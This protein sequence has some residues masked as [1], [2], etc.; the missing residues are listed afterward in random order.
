MENKFGIIY[1]DNLHRELQSAIPSYM[2]GDLILKPF[3]CHCNPLREGS[4]TV[5]VAI[6][7]LQPLCDRI[8]LLGC[9]CPFLLKAPKQGL[10]SASVQIHAGADLFLPF[11]S[12]N[13]LYRQGAYVVSAGWLQN[14]EKGLLFHFSDMDSARQMITESVKEVVLLDSGLHK[15]IESRWKEFLDFLGIPGRIIEVGVE[16]L[17]TMIEN[18]HQAWR[19]SRD[20]EEYS[21]SVRESNKKSANYAMISELVSSIVQIEDERAIVQKTEDMYRLIMSPKRIFFLRYP[22]EG[23]ISDSEWIRIE[24]NYGLEFNKTLNSIKHKLNEERNGFVQVVSF[25]DEI[26]GI[27]VVDELDLPVHI[28]EYLNISNFIV[29]VFALAL[30]NAAVYDRLNNTIS[31]LDMEIISRRQAQESLQ[32][33][34]KKLNLLS[35][36]TRHDINNYLAVQLGYLE[37]LDRINLDSTSVRY[38][39]KVQEAAEQMASMISFT[40]EYESIGI[41]SPQWLDLRETVS[42]AAR[43]LFLGP[44][45]LVNEI[46]SG[47]ELYSDPLIVKVF[48]NLIEN[49]IRY[50]EKNTFI[51]FQVQNDSDRFSIICEDDGFGIDDNQKSMIFNRGFGKNTGLGLF[52]SKEILSITGLG[53]CE[54]G[55]FGK[56]ARFQIDIP[57]GGYRKVTNGE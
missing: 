23:Q 36:I 6:T 42:E 38:L 41:S 24:K 50:G 5:D 18:R 53:I 40:K 12:V 54:N 26:Q 28:N 34:N 19:I 35:S 8:L 45:A 56:G 44:I 16:Q 11:A 47:F 25:Q 33:S 4:V 3:G 20:G 32:M 22:F 37:L 49:S 14:W 1:C 2:I 30:H 21:K 29:G 9:G 27:I 39:Q 13:Q 17:R 43:K 48:Y 31:E 15:G 57:P 55:E 51:R 52:L 10:E 7:A 46:P